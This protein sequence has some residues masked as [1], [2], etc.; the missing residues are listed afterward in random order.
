M[1]GTADA[2]EVA[3]RARESCAAL[4]QARG[5]GITVAPPRTPLR[6]G[7]DA[8]A[9]ERIL[10]P[11]LENACRYGRR[12]VRLSV[13]G[14]AEA[15]EFLVAD[16]GPGVEAGEREGIFEPGVRGTA[17]NGSAGDRGAGLGL[18]LA[19]QAPHGLGGR[20]GDLEDS[21]G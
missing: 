7:V 17:G 2:M 8:D 18:A 10:A 13:K 19:P 4:A 16:D 11:L 21:G 1:R 6:V 12:S 9:A 20:R 15:I 14:G 5:I 3:E